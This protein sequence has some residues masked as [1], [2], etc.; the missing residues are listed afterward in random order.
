[1]ISVPNKYIKF[2]VPGEPKGKGR[3]RFTKSGHTYTPKGTVDYEKLV[4][5]SYR[6]QVG[7]TVF[8]KGVPLRIEVDVYFSTPKS[9]SKKTYEKM[10]AGAVKPA[11]KPDVDNILKIIADALNGLAY[12][13]DA[14]IVEAAI[15]K[16]YS[17]IPRVDVIIKEA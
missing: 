2:N 16:K 8:E 11:K 9:V 1:M 5:L 7:N 3:P 6:Q 4:K 15:N 12:H 14:Q 10:I 17:T 13:D